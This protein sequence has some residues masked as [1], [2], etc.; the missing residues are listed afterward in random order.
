MNS[1]PQPPF[2]RT[3]TVPFENRLVC[4]ETDLKNE[5]VQFNVVKPKKLS[6]AIIE[7]IREEIISGRLKPGDKLPTERKLAEQIGV[8]RPPVREA[9]KQLIYGGF[10]ESSQGSGTYVRSITGNLFSEPLK[11][12]IKTS[13]KA[14]KELAI[15]R[16]NLEKWAVRE[17]A[18]LATPEQLERL[19]NAVNQMKSPKDM[20]DCINWDL[21]FHRIIA[22]MSQNAIYLHLI[23]SIS[24][25][26]I[27]LVQSEGFDL[28]DDLDHFMTIHSQIFQAIKAG[29]GKAAEAAMQEHMEYLVEKRETLKP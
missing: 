10:L 12:Q 24:N 21:E 14:F 11:E 4:K 6:E 13:P 16:G 29:D 23:S 1:F 20:N 17:A 25:L 7:Q 27:P 15:L 3:T 28:K 22:E 2:L 5:P 19:E 26:F 8:S 9:I 18:Q